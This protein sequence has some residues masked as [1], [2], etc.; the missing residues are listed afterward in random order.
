MDKRR[1]TTQKKRI[2][3][4]SSVSNS[5]HHFSGFSFSL[6][7]SGTTCSLFNFEILS[8]RSF[9]DEKCACLLDQFH[10][11]NFVGFLDVSNKRWVET[12]RYKD[13]QSDFSSFELRYTPKYPISHIMVPP[14][15]R[16]KEF[17][18]VDL[19]CAQG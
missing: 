2:T 13:I 9:G 15:A 19:L 17:Y 7:G 18:G 4:V 6:T 14:S 1:F 12:L 3:D 16:G 10:L 5:S 11:L 8:I